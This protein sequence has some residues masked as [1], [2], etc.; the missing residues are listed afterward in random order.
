M[1]ARA[2]LLPFS[3]SLLLACF[4]FTKRL[5]T[6]TLLKDVQRKR[7]T[8]QWCLLPVISRQRNQAA[9]FHLCG[10]ALAAWRNPHQCEMYVRLWG[11]CCIS[12]QTW[13]DSSLGFKALKKCLEN[14]LHTCIASTLKRTLELVCWNVLCNKPEN[15]CI[16]FRW[17]I[18]EA[19]LK[20]YKHK[21][22]G[23]AEQEHLLCLFNLFASQ[24]HHC[25]PAYM[26]HHST[27]RV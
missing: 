19:L 7:F 23:G 9:E 11:L 8:H 27:K 24:N 21:R 25:T 4:L 18:T 14:I 6:I 20:H 12:E 5:I 26:H 16:K 22:T 13:L 17:L 10:E 2:P 1:V 15:Y 3:L